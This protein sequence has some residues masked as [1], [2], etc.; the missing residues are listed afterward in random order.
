MAS[1]PDITIAALFDP[2]A[3]RVLASGDTLFHKGD[4][5]KTVFLIRHGRVR[6]LRHLAAGNSVVVYTGRTGSLLAEGALFAEAYGCDARAAE[7]SV[8]GS[9]ATSAVHAALCRSPALALAWLEHVTRQLHTARTLLELRNIRAAGDRVLEHLRLRADSYGTVA[10]S[11]RLMDAAAEL[12]LTHEAY[13]RSLSALQRSGSIRRNRNSI[14]VVKSDAGC[15]T[16]KT[17]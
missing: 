5:A 15:A 16:G 6:M 4:P 14:Q 8:V 13:Y 1:A 17:A 2:R 11:G 9:C 3:D 10:S 7:A 12:G